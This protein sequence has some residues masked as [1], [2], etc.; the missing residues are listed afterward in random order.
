MNIKWWALCKAFDFFKA[1]ANGST[2][3]ME[4]I[5]RKGKELIKEMEERP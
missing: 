2:K 5:N 4:R 3:M 1:I